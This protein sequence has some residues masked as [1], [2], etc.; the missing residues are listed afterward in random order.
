M[1]TV[2]TATRDG[3]YINS[4]PTKQRDILLFLPSVSL[5][6]GYNF[7]LM[8][9]TTKYAKPETDFLVIDSVRVIGIL[10]T[11][12]IRNALPDLLSV[13]VV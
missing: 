9:T 7:L 10:S 12:L 1:L 2:I 6:E 11:F 4:I 8:T 3:I 5:C 13:L